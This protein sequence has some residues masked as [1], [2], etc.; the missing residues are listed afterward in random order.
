MRFLRGL[1][2]MV[3]ALPAT[4]VYAEDDPAPVEVMIFGTY[5]FANPGLD[6]VNMEADDV[7]VPRR[8][9]ELEA[10]VASLAEWAP[11][12]VLVERES[13]APGFI[14]PSYAEFGPAMLAETRNERVQIGYRLAG[15]L[16]HESV[17]GFDEQPGE[18]EPDYFPMGRVNSFAEANDMQGELRQLFAMVQAV[19][20]RQ[21][22]AQATQSLAQLLMTHNDPAQILP[23][24]RALYYG[25][26]QFGDG[27]DQPG[28]ELNAYWYMRNAKMFA[29]L[30]M[31]AQPGDRVFLLV[32]SGHAY[33]LRHFVEETDG[34]ELVEA[35]PYLEAAVG[36]EGAE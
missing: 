36:A 25:L 14:D 8:Q 10:L 20:A 22:E 18:G 19:N 26:L 27:D 32:G 31:I 3:L 17:Y 5:H 4:V 12:R 34:F 35:M 28:A 6:V 23:M 15:R 11:H 2:L 7:L 1:F 21:E 33:W 24:H 30:Q 29:K 16:G 13:D 9:A